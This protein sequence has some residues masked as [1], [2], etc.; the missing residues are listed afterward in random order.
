VHARFAAVHVARRR[1]AIRRNIVLSLALLAAGACADTEPSA[2]SGPLGFVA[3]APIVAFIGVTVVPMDSERV[4]PDQIVVIDNGRITTIGSSGQVDVPAGA[5]R[6]DGRGRFLTPGLADMHVHLGDADIEAYVSA[7]ITTV[8]NMWGVP[9]MLEFAAQSRGP[10]STADDGT[11]ASPAVYSASPGIDGSPP[12]WAYTREISN[13]ADAEALVAEMAS[14]GWSFLKLYNRLSPEVYDA[15]ADAAALH[16]IR[17]LGHVPWAVTLEHALDRGHASIEHL[18]GYDRALGSPVLPPLSWTLADA[19]G[20]AALAERTAL[21]GTWNC[22]T[23]VVTNAIGRRVL[24]P[25]EFEQSLATRRAMVRAL[26]DAGAPLLV[27]TDGGIDIVRAGHAIHD[28]LAE[29]V[30]AGLTPFEALRAA[31][32]DAARFLDQ[33]GEF[34]MIVTGSRAD[35]LLL[36]ANPL[37]D[38]GNARRIAG[39]MIRGRWH[40]RP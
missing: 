28:E 16:G 19:G 33:E 21:A 5:T 34:G 20:A 17:F 3:T 27:G 39:V 12:T 6:I 36:D 13:P 32:S 11:R 1:L 22:P 38:I 40:A 35:L 31:T 30:A 4:L 15:L 26:R 8:R 10:L 24:T 37:A 2:P 29:F 9:G 23:L 25:A 14:E 18:T 7:G